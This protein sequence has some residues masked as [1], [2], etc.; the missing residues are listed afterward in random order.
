[1]KHYYYGFSDT[2]WSTWSDSE[3]KSWLVKNG[4]AKSHQQINREKMVKMVECVSCKSSLD[5]D[6]D[7]M[8]Q[9]QL[10]LGIRY[11]LGR[12]V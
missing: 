7:D 3:L 8:H 9:E 1:M 10:R 2:V 11:N 5:I 4:Y 12:L 6:T